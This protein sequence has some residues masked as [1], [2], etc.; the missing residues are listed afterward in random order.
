[1][2]INSIK[3]YILAL[4]NYFP[5]DYKCNCILKLFPFNSN[6]QFVHLRETRYYKIVFNVHLSLFINE[7]EI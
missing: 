5:L 7:E 3:L 1:M 2:D 4:A 6:T